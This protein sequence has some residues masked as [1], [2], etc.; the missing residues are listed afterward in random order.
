MFLLCDVVFIIKKLNNVKCCVPPS[1]VCHTLSNQSMNQQVHLT[2]TQ[3]LN[4]CIIHVSQGHNLDRGGGGLAR[5]WLCASQWR[6][7]LAASSSAHEGSSC[8]EVAEPP[9]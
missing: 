8:H 7:K 6:M 3:R 1:S 5:A 2:F 4:T 9:A